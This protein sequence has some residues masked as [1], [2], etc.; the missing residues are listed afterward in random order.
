VRIFFSRNLRLKIYQSADDKNY[1]KIV[2]TYFHLDVIA[3]DWAAFFLFWLSL[4]DRHEITTSDDSERGTGQ[5]DE[6]PPAPHLFLSPF[7]LAVSNFVCYALCWA[8]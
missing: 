7:H 1:P 8:N 2:S 4:P 6:L 3:A 5:E